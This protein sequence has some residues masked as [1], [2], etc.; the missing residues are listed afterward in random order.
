MKADEPDSGKPR[1]PSPDKPT[2]D[3]PAPDKPAPDR[4]APDRPAPDKPTPD[5]PAPDKPTPDRPAPDKPAPDKPAPDKPAPDKPAPDK[6]A[7]DKPAPDKPA[8]D[9]PAPDKPAPDKPAPRRWRRPAADPRIR[10]PRALLQIEGDDRQHVAVFPRDFIDE[11]NSADLQ[12]SIVEPWLLSIDLLGPRTISIFSS[13]ITSWVR[14]RRSTNIQ[15]RI[16]SQAFMVT[17]RSPES[18]VQLENWI[19]EHGQL[20]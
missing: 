17:A 7:P 16:G 3:R 18:A 8:P 5:R 14:S 4:P 15:V 6:P 13:V 19:T 1:E 2:P 11:L 9:K 10:V 12:I 20:R